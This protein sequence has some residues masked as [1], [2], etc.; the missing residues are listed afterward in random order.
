MINIILWNHDGSLYQSKT[1]PFPNPWS[2]EG[3]P[4]VQIDKPFGLYIRTNDYHTMPDE[5]RFQ[6]YKQA[7]IVK[8]GK[9]VPTR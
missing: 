4:F 5:Q 7:P 1:E 3:A 9:R 6:I 8:Q 2:A